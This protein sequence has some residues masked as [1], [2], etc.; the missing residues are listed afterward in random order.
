M[1]IDFETSFELLEQTEWNQY[2][3]EEKIN[4]IMI[5]KSIFDKYVNR[6]M[7]HSIL[8]EEIFELNNK[9][10]SIKVS[11]ALCRHYYDKGIP[12][13]PYYISPG[14]EG[15]SVQYFPNFKDEHWM[16]LY[17]FNHFADSVYMKLFSVWD[18]VTEILDTFYDLGIEKNMRFKFK[19]MDVLK[20]KDNAIWSFLKRDVLDNELYKRAGMYRNS[21]AHYTGPSTVS[22]SYTIQKNK[23]IELPEIQEDGSAK[24]IKRKANV[25]S[26]SAG[27]YTYVEDII[28]NILEF[29]DFTGR[30]IHKLLYDMTEN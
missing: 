11:Y 23:E 10:G 6:I 17:W 7:M 19:V 25:L 4:S 15:E 5:D 13:K 21:F 20:Q 3:S 24:L 16:R 8:V 29:S 18:S 22:N 9:V 27:D 12:D 2:L 26:Y 30:M 1:Q 28:K 14:K